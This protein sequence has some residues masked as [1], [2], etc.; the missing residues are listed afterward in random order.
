MKKIRGNDVILSFVFLVL[1]FMLSFSYQ[2][3][4]KMHPDVTDRQWQKEYEYRQLLI[5]AQKETSKL[6]NR[7]LQK[8]EQLQHSEKELADE[9]TAYAWLV[10]E[11]EQ[12]RM[13]TGKVKVQGKGV[14]V[15]LADASYVPNEQNA[16][17]YIVHEQHVWKVVHELLVSGAEAIAINGQ[18]ISHR[19]YIVCNGPVIE[20]D[21]VQHAAPFVIAAIGDPH[22]LASALNIAGGV[23]DELVNDHIVVKIASKESLVFDP[24]F[25]SE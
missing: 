19:S 1:G 14:E 21:G 22:V 17:N 25:H 20:V 11:V 2:H 9:K 15:T 5:Q 7:L 8:Q 13:Y 12:L 6:K 16:A 24:V 18:R 3:T 10:Q 4:K 23:K